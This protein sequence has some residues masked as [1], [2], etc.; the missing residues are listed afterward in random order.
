[1]AMRGF[2]RI[3][4]VFL[5]FLILF[6]VI[7]KVFI[8]VSPRYQDPENINRL[9]RFAKDIAFSLCNADYLR[10]Y[11]VNNSIP[12][13]D[14]N[15]T[16]PSD[17]DW[18]IY[19][20]SN[21]SN[22]HKLDNLMNQSGDDPG[23]AVMATSS[24]LIAG[25]LQPITDE[26]N[27]VSCDYNGT[28]CTAALSATDQN[29]VTFSPSSGVGFSVGFQNVGIPYRKLTMLLEGNKS[30]PGTDLT[31]FIV[32]VHVGE[33]YASQ[34]INSHNYSTSE[35]NYTFDITPYLPDG[36]G[37][38][39]VTILAGSVDHSFDFARLYATELVGNNAV[40]APKKI[41]VGVWNR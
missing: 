5:A 41:V 19:L 14:L 13:F 32:T 10:D 12:G 11:F 4:E 37:Q 24:C 25:Y 38:Y 26:F 28:D 36:L 15:W 29:Y 18:H 8:G 39:N 2:V 17:L 34:I 7:D 22:N 1:M 16:I 23:S 40:Y 31:S 21:I 27:V 6:T 30:Q 35:E 3:L 20:Y 9:G 33:T